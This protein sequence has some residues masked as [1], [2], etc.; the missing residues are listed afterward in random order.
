MKGRSRQLEMVRPLA[1]SI[2]MQNHNKKT[3]QPSQILASAFRE[4]KLAE[5]GHMAN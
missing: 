5:G 4:E 1:N 3:V 2:Q